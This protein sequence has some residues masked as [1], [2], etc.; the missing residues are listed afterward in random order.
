MSHLAWY[1][2]RACGLVAWGLLL[3]SIVWGLLYATRVLGRRPAPW[4]LLGVHRWLGALAVTF[5]G[6]HVGAVMLDGYVPFGP[7]QAFVPFVTGWHPVAVAWGIAAFYL[8]LA[9]EVTSLLRRHLSHRTW[10]VVHLG[11][12]LLFASATIHGL[13]AGTDARTVLAPAAGVAFGMAAAASAVAVLAVRGEGAFAPT[14]APARRAR[15]AD[16]SPAGPPAVR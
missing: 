14:R 11:S 3:A 4:W 8:L 9:I 7:A 1:V 10:H 5:V 12:Y 15:A 16:S 13:T 6:I 2:A